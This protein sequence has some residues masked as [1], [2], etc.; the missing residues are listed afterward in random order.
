LLDLFLLDL[1]T[2][3]LAGFA[4]VLVEE[5]R[6]MVEEGPPEEGAGSGES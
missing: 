4:G 6:D 5:G 3:L 1:Q 2:L